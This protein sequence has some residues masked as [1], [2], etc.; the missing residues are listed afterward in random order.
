MGLLGAIC[1]AVGSVCSAIGSAVSG[2]ASIASSCLGSV[3]GMAGA[4]G[5]GILGGLA[6]AVG[7][8]GPI[9]GSILAGLAMKFVGK[10]IAVLAKMLGLT[11][12]EEK[13]EE[14]GY[15][16]KE[17]QEHEDWKKREDFDTLEE[18][19]EYLKNQIPEIN[20]EKLN[21]NFFECHALGTGFLYHEISTSTGMELPPEFALLIGKNKISAEEVKLI[22]DIFKKDGLKGKDIIEYFQKKWSIAATE[23]MREKLLDAY[24]EIQ[25]DTPREELAAR[26]D[27]I[28]VSTSPVV[29]LKRYQKDF[30][31]F[32]NGGQLKEVMMTQGFS[33]EKLNQEAQKVIALREEDWKRI[34]QQINKN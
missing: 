6:A 9:V 23:D 17:A 5:K 27:S 32:K 26:L 31:T 3:M 1:S 28:S 29:F 14:V 16:L 15:R 10:I 25:P 4:I 13:P 34:A 22:L 24:A 11:E 21:K 33:E 19:N 30:D 12:K 20:R 7:G 18:Y 8:L 2:L